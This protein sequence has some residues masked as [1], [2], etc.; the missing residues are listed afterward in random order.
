ME[1]LIRRQVRQRPSVRLSIL[2]VLAMLLAVVAI[3]GSAYV[4]HRDLE[5]QQQEALL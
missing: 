4:V 3:G 2:T 5:L 1:F